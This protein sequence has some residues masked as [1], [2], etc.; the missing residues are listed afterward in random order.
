MPEVY[1]E[2]TETK[3]AVNISE[4]FLK[5]LEDITERGKRERIEQRQLLVD[6][7]NA[8]DREFD[9]PEVA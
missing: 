9:S 7:A 5:L 8:F 3:P 4:G 2:K 1:R 6:R